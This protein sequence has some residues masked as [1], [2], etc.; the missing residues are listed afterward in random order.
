MASILE[1]FS[2]IDLVRTRTE[3]VIGFSG[4]TLKFN[5]STCVDLNFPPYIQF[6]INE[7]EKQF[8]IKACKETD[9]NAIKFSKTAAEQKYPIKINNIGITSL[10]RK[11]MGWADTDSW[12]C[13]GAI[14]A[15]E[16]VIIY[17]LAAASA[18]QPKQGGW[19]AR[20]SALAAKKPND[21]NGS[22]T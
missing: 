6:F 16:G 14:F 7:R 22:D 13:P 11:L 17:S 4:I 20:K 12:N 8:A 5:N 19:N 15:E 21:N 9:P 2:L 10:V 1:K 18:P 3:S